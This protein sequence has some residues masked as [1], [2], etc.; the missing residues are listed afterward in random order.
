MRLRRVINR[1]SGPTTDAGLDSPDIHR[2]SQSLI[3]LLVSFQVDL[4]ALHCLFD[5]QIGP[6]KTAGS[7][8]CGR[9]VTC[10]FGNPL[11]YL[12]F[13][14]FLHYNLNCLVV[15]FPEAALQ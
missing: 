5:L 6:V 3:I 2:S 4:I 8:E 7:E 15:S 11:F 1:G 10:L 14:T 13:Y 9:T 12:A